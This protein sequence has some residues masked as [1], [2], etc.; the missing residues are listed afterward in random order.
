MCQ[1]CC[2]MFIRRANG[3]ERDGSE[4]IGEEEEQEKMQKFTFRGLHKKTV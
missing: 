2:E 4:C 3:K 1:I